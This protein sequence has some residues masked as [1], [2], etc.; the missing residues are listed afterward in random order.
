MQ[1]NKIM[2]NK[3]A[4]IQKPVVPLGLQSLIDQCLKIYPDQ[5]NPLQVTTVLKYW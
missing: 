4:A 2:E 5:P 1:Q 3:V